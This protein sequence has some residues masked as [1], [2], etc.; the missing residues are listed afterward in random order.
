[1]LSQFLTEQI[2]AFKARLLKSIKKPEEDIYR[3]EQIKKKRP[4]AELKESHGQFELQTTSRPSFAFIWS[5]R[6][7]GEIAFW[8]DVNDNFEII[9]QPGNRLK[10]T[11]NVA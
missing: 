11:K 2:Q 10:E 5:I 7:K 9:V 8:P 4:K 6:F 3:Y 1:M